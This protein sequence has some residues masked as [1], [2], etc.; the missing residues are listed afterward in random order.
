LYAVAGVW[1]VTVGSSSVGPPPTLKIIQILAGA[2][3]NGSPPRT[4]VHKRRERSMWIL[5]FAT[6]ELLR[7]KQSI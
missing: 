7:V 3:D 2:T 4:L 6:I 5:H 1:S